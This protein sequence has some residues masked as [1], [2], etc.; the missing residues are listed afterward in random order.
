MAAVK[1][2]LVSAD[3]IDREPTATVPAPTASASH[4]GKRDRLVLFILLGGPFIE[5]THG[6]LAFTAPLTGITAAIEGWRAYCSGEYSVARQN[7]FLT[8]A[9]RGP[10]RSVSARSRFQASSA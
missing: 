3:Q 5:S 8:R 9:T 2:F 1:E 7:W 4:I 6:N 10:S